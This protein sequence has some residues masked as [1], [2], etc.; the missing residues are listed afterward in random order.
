MR[1]EGAPS[2]R[3][4]RDREASE[5]G[6][7]QREGNPLGIHRNGWRG[8]GQSPDR[9]E[10]S[11]REV[12]GLILRPTARAE[13]RACRGWGRPAPISRS[14]PKSDPTISIVQMKPRQHSPPPL[15][16]PGLRSEFHCTMKT[17]EVAGA[18]KESARWP[19][20]LCCTN[21]YGAH[22]CALSFSGEEQ[23]G[24][25][26]PQRVRE[27]EQ[28][29]RSR[30][31]ARFAANA[32]DP[33]PSPGEGEVRAAPQKADPLFALG[34]LPQTPRASSEDEGSSWAT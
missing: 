24:P 34:A 11:V 28:R 1:P 15:R 22:E 32:L 3:G 8:L 6:S 17:L 20:V 18:R 14:E 23:L 10:R 9:F 27:S 25:F 4:E 31:R 26:L 29:Q 21:E 13:A 5:R 2:A 19:T 12:G 7:I 30:E 16:R 33:L